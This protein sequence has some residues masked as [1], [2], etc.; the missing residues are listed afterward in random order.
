MN[1]DFELSRIPE[2]ITSW[3]LVE[4]QFADSEDQVLDVSMHGLDSLGPLR[5]SD[6]RFKEMKTNN[7]LLSLFS[8]NSFILLANL[9]DHSGFVEEESLS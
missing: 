2:R 1:I 4:I 3:D 9:A 8:C 5:K 6:P 7:E